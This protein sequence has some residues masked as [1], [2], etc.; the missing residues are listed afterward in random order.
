MRMMASRFSSRIVAFALALAVSPFG[1][2]ARG[3]PQDIS[4]GSSSELASASEVEGRTGKGI[5]SAPKSVA[6]HARKLEQKIVARATSSSRTQRETVG[7]TGRETAGGTDDQSR[8]LGSTPPLG[9]AA[10]RVAG[11]EELNKQ[12]D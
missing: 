10:R 2:I 1:L 5:F 9:G 11:P 6:H 8:P 3:L 7:G 4:G 12:G